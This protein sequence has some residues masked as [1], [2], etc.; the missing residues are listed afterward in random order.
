MALRRQTV[1]SRRVEALLL[2]AAIAGVYIVTSTRAIDHVGRW[3]SDWVTGASEDPVVV[4]PA[5]GPIVDGFPIGAPATCAPRICD[6]WI[7][8]ALS[9]LEDREPAHAQVLNVR[10]YYEDLTN[11]VLY[12]PKVVHR[13]TGTV[14]VVVFELADGS[15]RATGV[16]CGVGPCVG[17]A[18]YPH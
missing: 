8:L 16:Y 7:R 13:R 18:S 3:I 6:E 14:V 4:R 9:A 1:R 12:D 17:L 5:A 15:R 11:P 10:T 2:V